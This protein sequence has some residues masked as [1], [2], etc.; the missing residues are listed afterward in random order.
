[1]A[2]RPAKNIAD[3]R[4]PGLVKAYK[5][6]REIVV[7]H[8]FCNLLVTSLEHLLIYCRGAN[9]EEFVDNILDV[10]N[11]ADSDDFRRNY[12]EAFEDI[13]ALFSRKQIKTLNSMMYDYSFLNL[14]LSLEELFE[15][16]DRKSSQNEIQQELEYFGSKMRIN[17]RVLSQNLSEAKFCTDRALV[18]ITILESKQQLYILYPYEYNVIS[19]DNDNF[20]DFREDMRKNNVSDTFEVDE[21]EFRS[22]TSLLSRLHLSP[23]A[24]SRRSTDQFSKS[25]SLKDTLESG[26]EK[27]MRLRSKAMKNKRKLGTDRMS[28]GLGSPLERSSFNSTDEFRLLRNTFLPDL[29]KE[30]SLRKK[31]EEENKMLREW[32]ANEE[33]KRITVVRDFPTEHSEDAKLAEEKRQFE[34]KRIFEENRIAEESRYLEEKKKEIDRRIAEKRKNAEERRREEDRKQAE[35]KLKA[36]ERALEEELERAEAA[37]IADQ[38]KAEERRKAAEENRRLEEQR[39]ATERKLKEEKLQEEQQRL[40]LEMT[41]AENNREEEEKCALTE[42]IKAEELKLQENK[43]LAEEKRLAAEK[44]LEEARKN[45]EEKRLAEQR[46]L[47][48]DKQQSG[49]KKIEADKRLADKKKLQEEKKQEESRKL[50][51]IQKMI[52]DKKLAKFGK[53][54]EDK[55]QAEEKRKAEQYKEEEEKRLLEEARIAEERRQEEE[56]QQEEDARLEEEQR[57]AEEE[58]LVEERRLEEEQREAERVRIVQEKKQ[59][60]QR[61]A[62]EKRLAEE[63]ALEDQ[64]KKKQEEQRRAHEKKLAEEKALEDQ[65]KKK[66]EDQ[67]KKEE[68]RIAR[69]QQK[70]ED[71]KIAEKKRLAMEARKAEAKRI[72]EERAEEERLAELEREA[73]ERR[74]EGERKRAEEKI[75]AEERKQEERK[76]LAEEKRLAEEREKRQIEEKRLAEQKKRVE[77]ETKRSPEKPSSKAKVVEEVKCEEYE[78]VENTSSCGGLYCAKCVKELKRS[79]Y[80]LKCDSCCEKYMKNKPLAHSSGTRPV[81]PKTCMNCQ[82]KITKGEEVLCMCCFLQSKII[83]ESAVH[84]GGCSRVDKCYWIDAGEG[85]QRDMILCGFCDEMKNQETTVKIC[86]K[87]EDRICLICLRKNPYVAQGICSH[88]HS[89]RTVSVV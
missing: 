42:R 29:E 66:Q 4:I 54:E 24:V 33:K 88:C 63:K 48:D 50:A 75:E 49:D 58:R 57:L 9:L 70:E 19:L 1:M 45:F 74:E 10:T 46:K 51:E 60:E 36:Y 6:C 77:E 8:L 34:E 83:G 31:L 43:R 47:V 32:K 68:A 41:E 40:I 87:C 59:E 26:I 52:N 44:R 69:E 21:E 85:D 17:I 67:T 39:L 38:K 80:L 72:A 27:R 28:S 37:R 73:E 53:L 13:E 64:A 81:P 23:V 78:E 35:E 18:S 65:A 55:R 12:S 3:V 56:K 11:V 62:H 79:N 61:R 7:P 84:C 14:I 89:R 20:N 25:P 2:I 15:V 86:T 16:P 82:V 22:Q 5:N 30:I 76:K 71:R